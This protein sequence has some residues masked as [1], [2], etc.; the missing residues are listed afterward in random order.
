MQRPSLIASVAAVSLLAVIGA[1]CSSDDSSSTAS[2]GTTST[3]V[4]SSQPAPS[5]TV[6]GSASA[7]TVA[8]TPPDQTTSTNTATAGVTKVNANTA[9]QSQISAALDA[10]GVQNPSRWAAEVVE[11]RPYPTSDPTFA[12]LR[13]NLAKYNPGPD[14]VE[15]I[16]SAL[17]L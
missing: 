12:K 6:A 5:T 11:Y 17:S 4:A 10:A 7:T 3:T 16:I 13:Q 14:T 8:T 2:Q 1:A 9:S 15:R